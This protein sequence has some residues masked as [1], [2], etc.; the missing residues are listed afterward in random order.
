M[1][2]DNNGFSAE[3]CATDQAERL[4][5]WAFAVFAEA[6]VGQ[7]CL[8]VDYSFSVEGVTL[9]GLAPSAADSELLAD[10]FWPVPWSRAALAMTLDVVDGLQGKDMDPTRLMLVMMSLAD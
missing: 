6:C 10:K 5:A 4:A 7:P 1:S 3:F 8:A 9:Y 2:D